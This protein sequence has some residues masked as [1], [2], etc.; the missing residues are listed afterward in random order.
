MALLSVPSGGFRI[1]HGGG[2]HPQGGGRQDT[3]FIDKRF[4]KCFEYFQLNLF[5]SHIFTY[6]IKNHILISKSTKTTN[7]KS[8][9]NAQ[10]SMNMNKLVTRA[11]KRGLLWHCYWF[12]VPDSG[13]GANPQGAPG[14]NFSIFFHIIPFPSISVANGFD[15]QLV[16]FLAF[17]GSGKYCFWMLIS[18]VFSTIIVIP[19]LCS[20][21]ISFFFLNMNRRFMLYFQE[22]S[23]DFKLYC[24][25][26]FPFMSGI[27]CFHVPTFVAQWSDLSQAFYV[28]KNWFIQSHIQEPI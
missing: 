2:A 26:K 12:P 15:F 22:K 28:I 8:F 16:M 27:N 25:C 10:L 3:I 1:S 9:T 17:V 5:Y 14:Y 13:G 4:T 6:Q 19:A 7:I 20:Y 23:G 18:V 21:H 24:K 11:R